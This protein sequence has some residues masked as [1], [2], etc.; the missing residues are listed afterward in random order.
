MSLYMIDVETDGPCPGKYS[1]VALGIARI[2]PK[3]EDRLL[4]SPIKPI[5]EFWIPDAL[6]I[7]GLTR[8]QCQTQGAAPE[9]VVRQLHEFIQQTNNYKRP[10]CVADNPGFDWGFLNYYFHVYAPYTNPFGWSC[11]HLGSFYKG[12]T[13][14]FFSSFKHLRKTSH[15]HNP[16]NDALGNAE[17]LTAMCEMHNVALPGMTGK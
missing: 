11:Q 13:S 16:L 12:L 7:S 17:A 4:I 3:M 5:S 14:N 10:M 1:M 6:A 15:D 8:E 9:V 2:S